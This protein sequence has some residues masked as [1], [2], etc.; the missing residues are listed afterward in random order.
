MTAKGGE[1][2]LTYTPISNWTMKFTGAQTK[3]TNTSI[4]NDVQGYIAL[5]MPV[6][7]TVHDDSGNLWWTASSSA[8]TALN[9]YTVNVASPL[10]LDQALLGKSNPQ[11]KEYTW[12]FLTK[13]DFTSG[14][15]NH[16]FVGGAVRWA[17]KSVIGYLGSPP[18]P[19]GIV[20]SLNVNSPLLRSGP[21]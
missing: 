20:R 17:D 15:L 6:W 1:L 16:F 14:I 8:G 10:H 18:D 2:D 4:E 19:D 21:V 3:A 12:R 9:F 5:R 11:V 7:T 13:Y